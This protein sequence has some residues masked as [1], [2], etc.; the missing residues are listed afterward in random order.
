[1]YLVTFVLHNPDLLE[2][3]I[4]AWAKIGVPGATVIPGTGMGR[5]DQTRFM[6]DDIPLIPS[7]KDFY[8]PHP[9]TMSRTIFTAIKDE[10]L[11]DKIVDVTQALV[12]DLSEPETGILFVTPI[13]RAYGMD[14]KGKKK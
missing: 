9:Q 8:E 5:L 7:L 6:R 2:E 3:V 12:G 14:K 4:D 10:S 11:I 13:L 1:M